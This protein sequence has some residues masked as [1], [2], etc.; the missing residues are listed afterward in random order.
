MNTDSHNAIASLAPGISRP[1]NSWCPC[2]ARRYFVDHTL[3][4]VGSAP[5]D[6]VAKLGKPAADSN[7][8]S[9]EIHIYAGSSGVTVRSDQPREIAHDYPWALSE[10]TNR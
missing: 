10:T 9:L 4:D 6:S 8:L 7:R 5:Y 1:H 3:G 2:W